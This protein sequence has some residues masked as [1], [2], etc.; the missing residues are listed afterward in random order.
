[1]HRHCCAYK[2][3]STVTNI[4]KKNFMLSLTVVKKIIFKAEQKPL[5]NGVKIL[6]L[7]ISFW[8]Y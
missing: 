7:K 1:M 6:N 8:A 2:I 5:L 4:A 3:L